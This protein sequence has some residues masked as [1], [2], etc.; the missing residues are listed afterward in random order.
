MITIS[1][2]EAALLRGCSAQHLQKQALAGQINAVTEQ[3]KNGRKK[4][5]IPLTELTEAEQIRYY[6][7]HGMELPKELRKVKT[8]PAAARS[9]DLE[10][11]SADQREEINIWSEILREW[12]DFCIG[13]P[14]KVQ[15]TKEFAALVAERYPDIKISSDVLYRKKRA[16]KEHG[17]C[18]L[19]DLRGGHNKGS[20]VIPDITWQAF[21]YYYLDE[22]QPPISKCLESTEQW[23]EEIGRT[24][25]LPLPSAN[26]F[27]RHTKTD[28]A[29]T[30]KIL[31]REGQK[32][33]YD[34][35]SPFIRRELL[36]MESNEW[37]V[38]DTHTLDIRSDN[39]EII[40]RLYLVAFMDVR[41][42]I[43]VGWHLTDH[44]SSQ[45][46]LIAIRKS[47]INHGIA[48]NI[49]VD[50]G[51]EFLTKDVGG[52]GHR[53][54]KSTKDE[55]APPP[56]FERLGIK[57]TNA[58]PK[59]AQAKVIERRF[60]DIKDGLSRLFD[61]FTGGN[62]VE[63]PERLKLV[64]AGKKGTIPTDTDLIKIVDELIEYKFNYEIYGGSVTEDK[65]KMKIDVYRENLKTKRVAEENELNLMLMRSS[66]KYKV[67]QRGVHNTVAGQQI[68][69][70]NDEFVDKYLGKEV[71]FR[72]DPEN[73]SYIR[74]YDLEDRFLMTVPTD[75]E[76]VLAYGASTEDI[77][78]AMGKTRSLNKKVREKLK[79]I[80]S[81]HGAKTALEMALRKANANKNIQL[82]N[83]NAVIQLHRPEEKV[84]KSAVG[85]TE[86]NR[87]SLDRVIENLER[88]NDE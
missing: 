52:L 46:T 3:T 79:V 37:W 28:I 71:Y 72:W 34:R 86:P 53:Q 39:G 38:G 17:V 54:K 36:G 23:L 61:T 42:G 20:S 51:R 58:I 10:S 56:V 18:G 41:S 69:Y 25:C 75:N 60:K 82:V 43:F 55:F 45:A 9:T 49:L 14:S 26:T 16:L 68:D 13:K 48:R 1:I 31:G 7:D 80:K 5:M 57:M 12:D 62:V 24:D 64:E 22:G 21:L 67:G 81:L 65:G 30:L 85:D 47:I 83:E 19:I 40:H 63:K 78:N 77:K 84:F 74:V 44:P 87:F 29:E 66:R 59:N 11:Y 88:K 50:N 6:S 73:L 15:A 8:K 70:W 27:Y 35:C 4:Y 2:K 33:F 32:A 76:A